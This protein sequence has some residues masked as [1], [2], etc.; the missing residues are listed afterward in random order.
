MARTFRRHRQSHPIADLNVTN[1]VDLGFCLLIIFMLAAPLA[2]EQTVPVNLPVESASEQQLVD[3]NTKFVALTID[4]KGVTYIDNTP[5]N[6]RDLAVRL[7]GLDAKNT[8]IRFRIEGSITHQKVISLM[9]EVK[10]SGLSR[11]TFDT[12]SGS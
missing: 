9:D 6:S 8:V 3:K 11:I 7:R 5:V 10:K 12:Q 4:A 1:L 2:N